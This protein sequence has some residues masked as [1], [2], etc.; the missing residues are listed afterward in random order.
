MT[1]H[2]VLAAAI[3]VGLLGVFVA[4]SSL[5]PGLLSDPG[6]RVAAGGVVVAVL[7]VSLLVADVVLPV[8]SSVVM[9]SL[10]AAYGVALGAALAALGS[11][12]A[13]GLAF[14]IGRRAEP[15]LDRI[16]SSADRAAFASWFDERGVVAVIVSRPVPIVAETVAGL[17]GTSTMP[18]SR[19]LAAAA[20]GV[21]PVSVAYAATGAAVAELDSATTIVLIVTITAAVTWLGG[22]W[23]RRRV[24]SSR[25][26]STT[27][28][29]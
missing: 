4:V 24:P 27:G 20:A 21:V 19:F 26:P 5:G 17:A 13:A 8:P 16:V 14:A 6:E 11:L 25:R 18:G 1:R 28:A 12:A 29:A 23:L 9:V 10:G 3:S 2:L 15:R 22:R 7:A